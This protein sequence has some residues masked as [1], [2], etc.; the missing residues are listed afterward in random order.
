MF[1][2]ARLPTFAVLFV[3]LLGASPASAL[4]NR[5]FVS[6]AGSD[7][8][9][10]GA[11]TSPCKTLQYVHDSIINPGGEIVIT[12]AG[13]YGPLTITKALTVVNDGSGVASVTQPAANANAIWINASTSDVVVLKGLELDG[14]WAAVTGVYMQS[15]SSLQMI[16]CVIRRFKY[17]GVYATPPN[18]AKVLMSNVAV[19]DIGGNGVTIMPAGGFAGSFQNLRFTN[20]L[21]GFEI[22]GKNAVAGSPI[23]SVVTDSLA[24][25]TSNGFLSTSSAGAPAPMLNLSNV[26]AIGNGIGV[27]SNRG[28]VRLS[29]TS[30]S[31]N[32]TGVSISASVVY[33][34]K[35]N[36]IVDNGSNVLGGTIIAVNPD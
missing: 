36:S 5:A 31:G 19:S 26:R 32:G 14:A 25:G 8:G 12:S 33:S 3:A 24:T 18:W 30:V 28:N 2:I 7:S 9:S 20:L 16:D 21:N 13:E 34:D 6:G 17:N 11:V 29:R 1:K 15:A 10:C 22:S 35:T 4:V 23:Y 27:I